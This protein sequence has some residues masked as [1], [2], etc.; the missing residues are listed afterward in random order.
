MESTEI[1]LSDFQEENR[2]DDTGDLASG[3]GDAQPNGAEADPTAG[4]A[5]WHNN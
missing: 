4:N 2:E 1:D 5:G 3:Q